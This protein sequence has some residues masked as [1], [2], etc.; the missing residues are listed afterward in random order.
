M[1]ELSMS[2]VR[3]RVTAVTLLTKPTSVRIVFSMAT[4]ARKRR[5]AESLPGSV[6]VS[7]SGATMCTRQY[8][9]GPTMVEQAGIGSPNIGVPALVVGMAGNAFVLLGGRETTVQAVLRLPVGTDVLMATGTQGGTRLIRFGVMTGT[10][11]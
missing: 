9:V 5:I 7:A 1:I 2:P 11:V 4:D 6:A 8:E 10:A 3:I